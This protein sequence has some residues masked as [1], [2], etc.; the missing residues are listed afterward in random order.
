MGGC[1]QV[2]GGCGWLWMVA[3]KSKAE[4]TICSL[5]AYNLYFAICFDQEFV[6]RNLQFI[7]C[8]V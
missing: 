7:Y 3:L 8:N 1:G 4:V 5:S 2:M 6:F